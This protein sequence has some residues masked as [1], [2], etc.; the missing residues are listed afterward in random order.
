MGKAHYFKH[1]GFVSFVRN[2]DVK[3]R[4]GTSVKF[5]RNQLGVSQEILAERA[6]LHRT[7]ICDVERG[8]RNVSLEIIE[9]LARALEISTSALFLNCATQSSDKSAAR[10]GPPDELV[11]IL[12]VEDNP[13]D[14]A[15]TM[16]ALKRANL[17][18]RIHV[19]RDGQAALD[20]LFCAGEYVHRRLD[21]LPQMILLDLI[22]PKIDGLE[23]LR[24]I[25]AHSQTR[26]I[27]V[28][29]L[30]VSNR[31]QDVAESRRL[32][33]KAYIVKPV[34]FQNFSEVVPKLNLQWAV[35]KPAPIIST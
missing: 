27:P 15:L 13:D 10:P 34:E 25:K 4:F 16:Q 24:R 26:S 14:E 6:D 19:V 33:A 17:A 32:G 11:D 1:T 20:F 8:S 3:K 23:V 22:L 21:N 18:N 31:S 29:V 35:L 12:F 7:Y 30:T 5:W 2:N 28:V 9:K